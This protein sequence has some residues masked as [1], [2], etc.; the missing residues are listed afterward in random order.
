MRSI[1]F[2]ALHFDRH[3]IPAELSDIQ[4]WP[5]I[6]ESAL[7]EQAR[8]QLARRVKAM[9]LYLDGRTPLRE[10]TRQTGVGFNDLY[11]MFKRCVARHEDG[12]IFGCRALIPY[13][14]TRAYERRASM[15]S[16]REGDASGVSGV[17]QQLLRRYPDIANWG[18]R[19][20]A[21]R[22]RKQA[23]LTE[24]HRKRSARAV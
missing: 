22:S 11:R 16:C 23:T 9:M 4:Q 13:K 17:F 14:H 21:D 2:C 10:I 12:R 1:A 6:D 5:T 15:T 19:K 24:V 18:E 8:S 7:S 20:V 3:S